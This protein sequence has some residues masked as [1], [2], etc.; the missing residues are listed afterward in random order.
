MGAV[1]PRLYSLLK[2]HKVPP[3]PLS[4]ILSMVGSA[5]HELA[6]WLTEVLE[7]VVCS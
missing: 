6:K 3:I 1:R 5:Q 7:P 2:T 4:P